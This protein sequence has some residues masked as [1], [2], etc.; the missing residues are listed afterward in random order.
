MELSCRLREQRK[1]LKRTQQ[2]IADQ[3]GVDVTT[4]SHYESGRRLPRIKQLRQLCQIFSISLENH[5]PI[6]RTIK[7]PQELIENLSNVKEIVSRRLHY[8]EDNSD[9]IN[10]RQL[11]SD[12]ILLR[13]QLKK[14]IDPV[15]KIWEDTMSAPQMEL[16]G[17]EDG[18]TIMKVNYNPDECALLF[19][20]H[21]LYSKLFSL[22][23][24]SD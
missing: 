22:I 19:E 14:A 18:Q 3:I 20:C 1:R 17:L 4:Y 8:L 13:D 23:Q 10:Q 21:R 11:T 9:K 24:E 12:V 7:Y 15:Q 2:E 16:E 5:F 6:V